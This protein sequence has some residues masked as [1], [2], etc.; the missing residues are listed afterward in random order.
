MQEEALRRNFQELYAAHFPCK[1]DRRLR[2]RG[3]FLPQREGRRRGSGAH[4]PDLAGADIDRQGG[5]ERYGPAL[6]TSFADYHLRIVE[7]CE[8]RSA[9]ELVHEPTRHRV[10]FV[11]GGEDLHLPIALASI[12]SKYLRELY[13]SAFNAWW[14]GQVSG[15]RPTAGYYTDGQRFLRDIAP[16]L[17]RLRIDRDWL[18]RC[19]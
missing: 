9:Y 13:M 2:H 17:A 12:Y 16:A 8:S 11:A 19:R 5:R 15:L 1:A 6:M 3:R 18:V 7:E 10:E 14:G 4:V